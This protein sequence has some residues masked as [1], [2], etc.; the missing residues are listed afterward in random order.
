[1]MEQHTPG[2]MCFTWKPEFAPYSQQFTME[3]IQFGENERSDKIDLPGNK[4]SFLY[5]V[6]VFCRNYSASLIAHVS[7]WSCRSNP[8]L[9]YATP[10]GKHI[11]STQL[12]THMFQI[13]RR[14][15]F[16]DVFLSLLLVT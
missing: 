13:D 7:N 6:P 4:T 5:S 2:N 11:L 8:I 15:L 12:Y 10:P 3:I 14:F 16:S 9:F 1:M